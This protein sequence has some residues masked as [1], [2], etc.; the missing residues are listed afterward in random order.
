MAHLLRITERIRLLDSNHTVF[1]L[2]AGKVY[3]RGVAFDVK[4]AVRN[5][6]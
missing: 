4:S 2:R 6:R 5:T 3:I 1:I